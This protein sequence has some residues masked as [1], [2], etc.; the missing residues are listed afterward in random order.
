MGADG[1]A[2]RG[3]SID[4]ECCGNN[5]LYLSPGIPIMIREHGNP[6]PVR[7]PA[8]MGLKP[9]GRDLWTDPISSV[10]IST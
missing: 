2:G 3:L 6:F 7:Q 9:N 10:S 1:I 4:P 8:M 5:P